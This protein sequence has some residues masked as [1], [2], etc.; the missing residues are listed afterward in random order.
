MKGVV[1]LSEIQDDL[2]KNQLIEKA[3]M[4]ESSCFKDPWPEPAL[5]ELLE[6]TGRYD[7]VFAVEG[8]QNDVACQTEVSGYAIYTYV[9]DECELLRIAVLPDFRRSGYA[10]LMMKKLK[11][12]W[13]VL[14][15]ENIFLEVRYGNSEA[16]GLYEKNGF[17]EIALRKK[18][19]NDGEDAVIYQL[20]EREEI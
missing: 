10:S 9:L 3:A 17:K 19:Y 5:K 6:D 2:L 13:R 14:L 12:A 15:L 11:E 8:C 20:A 16:R 4:I 1:L 18:Y 7:A